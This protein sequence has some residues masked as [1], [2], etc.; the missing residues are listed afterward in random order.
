MGAIWITRNG[1]GFPTKKSIKAILTSEG[2]E[3]D[4]IT[5]NAEWSKGKSAGILWTR[6][7]VKEQ[8]IGM[9]DVFRGYGITLRA[10]KH[11]GKVHSIWFHNRKTERPF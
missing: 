6:S 1:F 4:F 5:F 8:M 9:E 10:V 3:L 11:Y 7:D 2:I